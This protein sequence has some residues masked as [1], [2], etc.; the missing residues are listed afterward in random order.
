R[1]IKAR[2]R[3]PIRT[4][5][6][7]P[8]SKLEHKK[9]R[10]GLTGRS[11]GRGLQDL[12]VIRDL[13][14]KMHQDLKGID[15]HLNKMHLRIKVQGLHR[16]KVLE[17]KMEVSRQVEL[18]EKTEIEIGIEIGNPVEKVLQRIIRIIPQH[19]L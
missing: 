14:S 19:D 5:A 6:G 3:N 4:I 8:I 2:R 17:R 15:G 1:G 13:P 12:M 18:Q 11:K 16:I 7:L 10:T 9:F